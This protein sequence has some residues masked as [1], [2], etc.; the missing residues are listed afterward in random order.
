MSVAARAGLL[1]GALLVLLTGA[2][3]L[4][5]DEPAT[6]RPSRG[7]SARGPAS[8]SGSGTAS[9]LLTSRDSVSPGSTARPAPGSTPR[10]EATA[11][12]LLPPIPPAAQ[13]AYPEPDPQEVAAL[14][15]ASA[16]GDPYLLLD[17]A[18][19]TRDPL[20]RLEALARFVEGGGDL[21]GLL[22]W[23]FE[24]DHDPLHAFV[25]AT[26]ADGGT[27]EL[28]HPLQL[29]LDDARPGVRLAAAEALLGIGARH[30]GPW[31]RAALSALRALV[32]DPQFGH[33]AVDRLADAEQDAGRATLEQLARD[34]NLPV[35][36]REDAAAAL[37]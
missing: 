1:G 21:S 30:P 35:D 19:G 23:G 28:V 29:W 20:L 6:P 27:A 12:P 16:A 8:S 34:P 4:P 13:A 24:L 26:L 2:L 10:R 15:R 32:A 17:V 33:R 36:V 9:P 31:V 5:G 7:A 25:G 37:R 11:E 22:P 14:E 3:A 18:R